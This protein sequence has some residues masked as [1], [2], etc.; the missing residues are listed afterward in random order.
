MSIFVSDD[1]FIVALFAKGVKQMKPMLTIWAYVYIVVCVVFVNECVSQTTK[2]ALPPTISLLSDFKTGSFGVVFIRHDT[3]TV[4]IESRIVDNNI[5]ILPDTTC[6]ITARNGIIFANTGVVRHEDFIILGK[7]R[8]IISS[9]I[10]IDSVLN[11]FS[12]LISMRLF[13]WLRLTNICQ[14]PQLRLSDYLVNGVF[15]TFTNGVPVIYVRKFYPRCTSRGVFVDTSCEEYPLTD[16]PFY[17]YPFGW[18]TPDAV[19]FIN[20]TEIY[21]SLPVTEPVD[22]IKRVIKHQTMLNSVH[23]GGDIRIIQT[24]KDGKHKWLQG[25]PDYEQ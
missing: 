9:V 12:G 1:K 11:N 18:H 6:K 14:D 25:K 21:S 5:P 17:C 20:S 22:I 13:G 7:A 23:I 19:A 8:E 3:I 24:T 2:D 10:G 4:G 16:Q 15:C